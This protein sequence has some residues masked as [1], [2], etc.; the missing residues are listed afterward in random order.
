MNATSPDDRGPEP[1]P[2]ISTRTFLIGFGTVIVA[3]LL[4]SL[5]VAIKVRRDAVR[6]TDQIRLVG[7]AIEAYA[8][9]HAAFP[10]SPQALEAFVDAR[11]AVE[12]APT[13]DAA[14][15]GQP[16]A[17]ADASADPAS[18]GGSAGRAAPARRLGEELAA[19]SVGAPTGLALR[20][21]LARVQVEWPADP[22]VPPTLSAGGRPVRHGV[23][24]EV[25]ERLA[26]CA[27][28]LAAGTE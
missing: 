24:K 6:F 9:A 22:G 15:S 12:G 20:A 16:G 26:T 5:V 28:R 7:V 2:T 11:G 25:T 23:V 3:T 17:A 8:E 4:F 1:V 27:E 19:L 13:G 10:R 14:R 21:A 18:V